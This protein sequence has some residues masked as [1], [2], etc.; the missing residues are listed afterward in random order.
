MKRIVLLLV[1][2]PVA[3][4][5]A[6]E[7]Q[8][9]YARY[10]NSFNDSES[11]ES[12]IIMANFP[13]GQTSITPDTVLHVKKDQNYIGAAFPDMKV[14][15]TVTVDYPSLL[16]RQCWVSDDYTFFSYDHNQS[17]NPEHKVKYLQTAQECQAALAYSRGVNAKN[18]LV[19][20]G[21]NPAESIFVS[22]N[23]KVTRAENNVYLWEVAVGTDNKIFD[24]YETYDGRLLVVYSQT[25]TGSIIFDPPRKINKN[26]FDGAK[27]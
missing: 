24:A 27:P 2:V 17:P 22:K 8:Q 14:V 5:M 12:R 13:S 16:R 23:Y 25:K 6:A 18:W 4:L 11:L 9:Y 3:A 19:A 1:L 10:C 15:L 21:N 20:N 7:S 26:P